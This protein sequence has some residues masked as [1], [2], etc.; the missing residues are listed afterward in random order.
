M[1]SVRLACCFLIALM[2]SLVQAGEIYRCQT[3][4]GQT[5]FQ[6]LPCEGE[7][8]PIISWSGSKSATKGISPASSPSL[9]PA[10]PPPSRAS[11]IQAPAAARHLF[12]RADNGAGATLYLLG[13]IHFGR[14]DMYPLPEVIS[15]AFQKS[16]AL[17]VE[18]DALSMDPMTAARSFAANGMYGGGATLRDEVGEDTWQRLVRAG[19][20]L[21]LPSAMLNAQ[22]P[23]LAAMTLSG[24]GVR[25]AGFDESQGIDMHFLKLAQGKLP[26]IELEGMA[27]QAQLMANLPAEAQRAMLADTLRLLEQGTDYYQRMVDIWRGGDA[28]GLEQLIQESLSGSAA[29]EQLN[30][31]ILDNRNLA[32]V[33]RLNELAARGGTYFVVVGAAHLVGPRGIVAALERQGYKVEQR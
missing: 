6:D 11:S 23:W 18:L 16:D 32:M 12:W 28:A 27:Y 19:E 31:V 5:V 25:R 14:P 24:L 3:G 8:K 4:E 33:E 29:A 7:A 15:A 10:P 21:G 1:K 9:L 22:K 17:V 30:K 2:V 20:A 26:V 13:S